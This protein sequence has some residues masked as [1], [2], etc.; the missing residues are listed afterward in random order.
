[1]GESLLGLKRTIMC[2]ELRESNI[3]NNVTVMGWVQRKR[4]LGG[5]VFIDL[6]DRTGILQVVFG[7][8]INKEAFEKADMAKSEYCIAVTGKIV[9]R[10]SP[11]TNLPTG[12]VELKG[13]SIKI[14]SESETPPIYIKENLDAAENIR[15]KYRYLDLRRP[16]MQKILMLRHKTTKL[17]R[18]YFDEN[19]FLEMETPMLTKSTPEGARDYLVPSR[20]YPGMFYALPQSPQ[21]FKQLLMVSGF[22]KYFQIVKCFRDE[23]LRANRQPEFTQIDMELSFVEVDDVIDLNERLLQRVFK[24]IKGIDVQLPIRRMPY[25]EAMSKYG[26]D[27][28]DLRFGMEIQDITEVVK[29]TEFAVFKGAIEKGG[30]V[31]AIVAKGSADMGRKKI[32]KLGEFVKTYKAKGLAWIANKQDEIKSPIAKF[33][34]EEEMN[35]ILNAAGAEKG[36]LVLIVADEDSVVLQSLGALRLELAKELGILEGNKE[37]NFV[38]VT[39]FPMFEYSEE[40][41]RYVAIHHP[42]TAPMDEDLD[43]LDTDPIHCRAKAYDIVLNGEELGGGSIRIHDTALQQKIFNLLGFTSESAWERFG[44]MLEAFKFGPPPHGGLAYGLDRMVMFLAGT[45]NIKDVIAFPKN[46]NAYCPMSE[47]PNVVDKKQLDDLGIGITKI[48]NK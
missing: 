31:R 34:S 4:N 46:Q 37:F 44:F 26:S 16:D 33:F 19:G 30:S 43:M 32:D 14:L 25:A 17:I 47:A 3:D 36:D 18:D 6:R 15:L 23:D 29:G 8:A 21:I 9:K 7:E 24:E 35:N 48:E 45:D 27:K 10:E 39:E 28:P 5:L 20:N 2:G 38:W 41:Q 1:M 13:E 22:D 12:M 42:F 11:N 40:E